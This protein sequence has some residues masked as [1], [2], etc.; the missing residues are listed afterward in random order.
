M[1]AL[2]LTSRCVL[3][4]HEFLSAQVSPKAA[5]CYHIIGTLEGYLVS[6]D[7]AITMGYVAKRSGMYK[8]R[9]ILHG[10]EEVR[11]DGI[12]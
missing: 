10:L 3:Y 11:F 4:V 7:G 8:G 12:P 5:L 9:S 1:P 6:H 2:F